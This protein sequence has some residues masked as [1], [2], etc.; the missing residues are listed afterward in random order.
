MPSKKPAKKAPP[1]RYYLV[2]EIR[3]G[4]WYTIYLGRYLS[5]AQKQASYC[6]S[7]RITAYVRD[8][9]PRKRRSKR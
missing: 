8:A 6:E 7:P 5:A 9:R 2:E 3:H 4:E 1:Q